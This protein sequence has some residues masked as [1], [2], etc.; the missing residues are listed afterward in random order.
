MFGIKRKK[1]KETII[2]TSVGKISKTTLKNNPQIVLDAFKKLQKE[3]LKG[4][5]YI[6]KDTYYKIEAYTIE[7]YGKRTLEKQSRRYFLNPTTKSKAL[8]KTLLKEMFT[9]KKFLNNMLKHSGYEEEMIS[10]G[11]CKPYRIK[12]DETEEDDE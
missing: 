10:L 7:K 1:T 4:F 6:Y 12:I 9:K 2:D 8:L 3:E 11:L 5:E